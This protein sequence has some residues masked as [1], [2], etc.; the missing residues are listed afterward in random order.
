MSDLHRAVMTSNEE[1]REAWRAVREQPGLTPAALKQHLEEMAERSVER[2]RHDFMAHF[3]R[4]VKG[5][6]GLAIGCGV[7]VGLMIGWR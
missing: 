1:L 7:A 6:P 3:R 2:V 5:N 4:V